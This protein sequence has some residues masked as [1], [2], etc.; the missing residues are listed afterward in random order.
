MISQ[1]NTVQWKKFLR[2]SEPSIC[3]IVIWEEPS[4]QEVATI[5]SLELKVAINSLG[6]EAK[7]QA[8]YH[9]IAELD[10]DGSGQIEFDEFF[11]MMTTRPSEN[12]SREEI[13]KVFVTFDNQK[14]GTPPLMQGSSL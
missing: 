8:V 11:Y 14:T 2:S 5:L 6:I 9:M 1:L 3:S 13:H 4:I 12:E 7:A 10:Q